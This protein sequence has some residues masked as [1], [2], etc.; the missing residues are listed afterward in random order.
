MAFSATDAAFE[1]FKITRSRPPAALVWAGVQ[2]VLAVA[3][4]VAAIAIA[5]PRLNALV[6]ANLMTLLAHPEQL[7]S[8]M[9]VICE[10]AVVSAVLGVIVNGFLFAAA[11]RSV[12]Q[13][14]RGGP[15]W[16]AFGMDELRQVAVLALYVIVL[17][18]A[19]VAGTLVASAAFGL[20]LAPLF[21]TVGVALTVVLSGLVD[22]AFV[23]WI[24]VRLSLAP[25][26]TFAQRR[27]VFF[28][29]WRLT[30]GRFWP[31]LGGYLVS[32]LMALLVFL[33]V[34]AIGSV[35]WLMLAGSTT[36]ATAAQMVDFASL[37]R[38][39]NVVLLVFSAI[40]YALGGLIVLTP[41]PY[42]YRELAGA[43]E[44]AK[45]F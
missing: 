27:I 39:A 15:G 16:L 44:A 36:D 8:E 43:A 14:A 21:G 35:A 26:A 25:A 2:L 5:G 13:P 28:D 20:I 32:W 4:R 37:L 34:M 7:T 30:R 3:T 12:M 45:A 1:G 42:A 38:P 11:A 22:L 9:G 29:T 17:F 40:A 31:L 18:A 10:V 19:Y 33:L 6:G 23:V 41:P 24:G